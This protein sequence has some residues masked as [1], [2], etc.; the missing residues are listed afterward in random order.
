MS[1]LKRPAVRGRRGTTIV[2]MAVIIPVFAIFVAALFEFGHVFLVVQTLNAAAK[3]G[4][5]YGAVEGI[6]SDDVAERINQIVG[7]AFD[8]AEV[9]V[10][11][12]DASVYDDG[13]TD[14]STID[15]TELPDIEL[16]NAQWRQLYVVK[17]ELHYDEIAITKP[18]WAESLVLTGQSVMRHE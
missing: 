5:R 3:Q 2:E 9:T 8:P 1:P 17:V 13:V 7:A 14:P 10:Y 6:T 16:T 11:I 15:V 18:F 12:K 4:A